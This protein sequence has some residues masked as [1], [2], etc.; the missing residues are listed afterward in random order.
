MFIHRKQQIFNIN[1][2]I[3]ILSIIF[4]IHVFFILDKIL[5]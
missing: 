5:S 2:N 4:H 1:I 3:I